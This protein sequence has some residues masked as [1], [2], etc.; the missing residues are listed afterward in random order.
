MEM[1][2]AVYLFRLWR[3]TN[4]LLTYL[5]TSCLLQE[6][7]HKPIGAVLQSSYKPGELS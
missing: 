1:V 6:L 2:G 4:R 3:F 7:R 5:L